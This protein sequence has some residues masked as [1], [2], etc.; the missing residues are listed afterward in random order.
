MPDMQMVAIEAAQW[1]TYL[2]AIGL[3]GIGGM[4]L[5]QV[6]KLTVKGTGLNTKPLLAVGLGAIC[7]YFVTVEMWQFFV[8]LGDI[9][10]A[11]EGFYHLGG[12]LGAGWSLGAYMLL[13]WAL[14]KY[15]PSAAKFLSGQK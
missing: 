4:M 7:G 6:A 14:K 5:A 11:V 12:A 8:A 15:A 1:K 2:Y 9:P 13:I 3:G 10:I